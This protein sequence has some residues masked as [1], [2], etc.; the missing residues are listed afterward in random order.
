[1]AETHAET[2]SIRVPKKG[3]PRPFSKHDGR[4][5]R[6]PPFVLSLSCARVPRDGSDFFLSLCGLLEASG[7]FTFGV[8]VLA[9]EQGST[10]LCDGVC[11]LD[12]A[13]ATCGARGDTR[14][15]PCHGGLQ[16]YNW[17][18]RAALALR[19][20]VRQRGVSSGESR[21]MDSPAGDDARW[22]CRWADGGH[23]NRTSERFRL[24][25]VLEQTVF[26]VS[27]TVA[28]MPP[29]GKGPATITHRTLAPY[30][31]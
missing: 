5:G 10:V 18:R 4:R 22:Q 28:G 2:Q 31:S 15:Q 24:S 6:F 13:D 27:F 7:R 17:A 19:S 25:V 9:S 14:V 12:T 26:L 11:W 1:M 30:P 3:Y 21:Q 8:S 23:A 20:A 16:P 29:T